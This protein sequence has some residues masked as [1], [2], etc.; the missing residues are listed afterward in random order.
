[1]TTI[2]EA[3]I[4]LGTVIAE[5]GEGGDVICR[6]ARQQPEGRKQ[7]PCATPQC[8]EGVTG[9]FC[10]VTEDAEC[11]P[12][13][14]KLYPDLPEALRHREVATY[15]RMPFDLRLGDDFPPL[16]GGGR[17]LGFW[18]WERTPI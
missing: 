5:A 15:R 14:F 6:H 13:M 1:M 18:F 11:V 16:V 3:L 4:R 17:Q 7:L 9:D 8:P 10:R 12:L 2:H